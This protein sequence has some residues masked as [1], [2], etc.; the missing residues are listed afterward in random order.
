MQRLDQTR[1]RNTKC[2]RPVSGERRT[3]AGSPAVDPSSALL[4]CLAPAFVEALPRLDGTRLAYNHELNAA[5]IYQLCAALIRAGLARAEDWKPCGEDALIFAKQSVMQAIG[6]E[7]RALL[8]RN[9]DFYL[10]I[11]DTYPE[12]Y[13]YGRGPRF[14]HA[15]AVSICCGGAGAF[16]VGKLIDALEQEAKGLGAAFYWTLIRSLN[17]VMRVYY[18][19]DALYYEEMLR[20]SAKQDDPENQDQYEFPEVKK[21]L[22]E[23]VRQ[24][25]DQADAHKDRKILKANRNGPFGSWIARLRRLEQLARLRVRDDSDQ[26]Q[27][28]FDSPPLPCLLVFFEER[29]AITACFDEEAQ[30]MLEGSREPALFAIFSP[31]KEEEAAR[32]SAIVRRF[33]AFNAELFTLIE[34]VE[35]WEKE[36][37]GCRNSDRREPPLRAA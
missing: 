19:D 6:V 12:G 9:V 8:E 22:P 33:V 29:D 10:E 25:L 35:A 24:T 18:H 5:L 17:Q 26:I 27:G 37:N 36:K 28:N 21:A 16:R 13:A 14:D 30:A 7:P 15:L 11:K 31:D 2:A 23:C 1:K 20:E 32:A 4:T 34:E 3:L